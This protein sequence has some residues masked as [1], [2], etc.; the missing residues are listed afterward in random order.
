MGFW[1]LALTQSGYLL[2]LTPAIVGFMLGR[3]LGLG[4]AIA[5]IFCACAITAALSLGSARLAVA[6]RAPTARLA[7]HFLGRY[8][9]QWV[10]GA[11]AFCLLGWFGL[12]VIA[13]LEAVPL[14]LVWPAELGMRLPL[15][16]ACAAVSL[17]IVWRDNIWIA[18]I[19]AVQAPALLLVLAYA[20]T[21]VLWRGEATYGSFTPNVAAVL[22]V[23]AAGLGDVIDMPVILHKA[24]SLRAA[25][26]SVLFTYGLILPG[27]LCLGVLLAA[28][29]RCHALVAAL[30]QGSMPWR[31]G[32]SL[33]AVSSACVG[34]AGLLW[35][36]G[37][38]L[39]IAC[40]Q[41]PSSQFRALMAA[42]AVAVA[43]SPIGTRIDAL[44]NFLGIATGSVG[45]VMLTAFAC[46]A[47][48]AVTHMGW[49]RQRGHIVAVALS[50]AFGFLCF[51]G[52]GPL[53]PQQAIL[54]A[55]TSACMLSLLTRLLA[56]L[57]A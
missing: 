18:R 40:K 15:V 43:L 9:S 37:T 20:A 53:P 19:N 36:G 23:V 11:L 56:R 2:G 5:S 10:G 51:F 16:V 1:R 32:I 54:A 3:A 57:R 12:H 8:G 45:F 50:S 34:N 24:S 47:G 6:Y 33:L 13:L 44:L 4:H 38:S 46:D 55:C 30:A 39:A 31:L 41:T 22:M 7:Q 14:L 48:Q 49:A 52:L 28:D 29:N 42:G 27:M 21:S 26:G 25:C 17:A 35:S